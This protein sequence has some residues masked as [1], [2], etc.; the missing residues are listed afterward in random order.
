MS[1]ML[2]Q[3]HY[4]HTTKYTDAE[5][6]DKCQNFADT[7]V[8]TADVRSFRVGGYVRDEK[9]MTDD[10]FWGKLGE[11]ISC[12]ELGKRGII[13]EPDF[14]IFTDKNEDGGI[15]LVDQNHKRYTIKTSKSISRNYLET[16]DNYAKRNLDNNEFH[17][18][19]RYCKTS[20]GDIWYDVGLLSHKEFAEKKLLVKAGEKLPGT[21]EFLK[22]DNWVVGVESFEQLN[23]GESQ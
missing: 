13:V 2:Q 5:Q 4:T 9:Q 1:K 15:D 6:I 18:A 20:I 14:T 21:K 19:V 7:K 8:S 11:C 23:R 12:L 16:A 22:A 3:Y 10:H 17:I